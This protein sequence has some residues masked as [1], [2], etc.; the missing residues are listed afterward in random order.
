MPQAFLCLSHKPPTNL[1]VASGCTWSTAESW[2]LDFG[3]V[4]R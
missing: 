4:S 3:E 1:K 2:A